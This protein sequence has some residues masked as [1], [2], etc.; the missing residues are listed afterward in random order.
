MGG[1]CAFWF[2]QYAVW[3]LQNYGDLALGT[4]NLKMGR[5]RS[6]Q[7][8]HGN[9]HVTNKISGMF[10]A[11]NASSRIQVVSLAFVKLLGSSSYRTTV[12]GWSVW[13]EGYACMPATLIKTTLLLLQ[14]VYVPY[15][16]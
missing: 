9:Q 7:Q 1:C 2:V 13:L 16:G 8:M 11:S 10:D 5:S 4:R 12:F 3:F 15:S 6:K 14:L